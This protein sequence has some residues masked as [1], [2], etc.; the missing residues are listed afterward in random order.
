MSSELNERKRVALVT[1]AARGIGK[2]IALRLASDGFSV[3]VNDVPNNAAT[4]SQ[5]VQEIKDLDVEALA[6]IADVSI[7]DE[8]RNMIDQVIAHFPTGRLDVMVANAGIVKWNSLV[9]TTAA[10]WDTV[11][12]VNACGTFLCYKY[13]AIQMIRQ[14]CGGRIIGAASVCGKKG[15]CGCPPGLHAYAKVP[16]LPSLGAYCASKFAIRG[17]TQAAAM[18]LGAHG[19]TVN[20]YAPGGIDTAMLGVLAS[21]N[22]AVS[23]RTPEDYF[24][25]LKARTPM[26]CIGEPSDV[27]NVVSF[28]ASK[29]SQFITGQSISVNGGTYFD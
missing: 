25:A 5:V 16:G 8:V 21:G 2:A 1:G 3:A 9:D 26:G 24:Q 12:T 20:A 19:I 29:E 23:G 15:T 22:A 6:C 14:G 11:M 10:D 18:E 4:L 13:A 7:E 27:A 28:L 17:L